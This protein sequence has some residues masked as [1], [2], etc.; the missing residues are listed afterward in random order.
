MQVVAKQL[1]QV[2]DSMHTNGIFH[3]DIKLE[4]ILI[5]GFVDGAPLIKLSDFGFTIKL[6]ES[7]K[8]TNRVGT[9][10]Y[11]APEILSASQSYGFK[12]DVWAAIV[13]IFALIHGSLPFNGDTFADVKKFIRSYDMSYE[14][15]TDASW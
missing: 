5:N 11:M 1:F 13:S 6:N 10:Y 2:L 9:Y 7:D 15:Q 12:A 4:N 3:R 8:L 14:I